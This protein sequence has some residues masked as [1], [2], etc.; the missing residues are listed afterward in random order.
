MNHF[1]RED[2]GYPC[3]QLFFLCSHTAI[4]IIHFP[5]MTVY[6]LLFHYSIPGG[7]SEVITTHRDII[8]PVCV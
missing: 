2:S 3:D 5:G 4:S 6:D 1:P 8:T 7:L